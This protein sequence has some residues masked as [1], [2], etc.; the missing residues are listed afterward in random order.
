MTSAGGDAFTATVLVETEP[1]DDQ[2]LSELR[3]D[4]RIEFIDGWDAL[5]DELRRLRPP[6]DPE[7]VAEALGLL[8]LATN[9]HEHPRAARLSRRAA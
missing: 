8:P 6:P 9:R 5:R 4:S 7:A 1:H 3:A 2:L